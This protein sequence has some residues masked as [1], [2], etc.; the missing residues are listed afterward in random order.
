MVAQALADS[1]VFLS[2]QRLYALLRESG[3]GV[4]LTTVYRCLHALAEAGG[5]ETVI[6]ESGETLYRRHLPTGPHHHFLVCRACGTAAVIESPA[7]E[8]WVAAAGRRHGYTEL[9]HRLEVFGLC[10]DCRAADH[11]R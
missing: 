2:A 9:A 7:A 6:S 4:G 1:G 10:R 11:R 5:A 3:H 8:R